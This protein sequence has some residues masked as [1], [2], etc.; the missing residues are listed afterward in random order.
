M[1][2]GEVMI[3]AY[4]LGDK[5]AEVLE[6]GTLLQIALLWVREGKLYMLY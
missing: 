5:F 4:W 1:L 6:A 2:V 3:E